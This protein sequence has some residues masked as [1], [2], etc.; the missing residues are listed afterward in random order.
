M[1]LYGNVIHRTSPIKR[2]IS[3]DNASA[4]KKSKVDSSDSESGGLIKKFH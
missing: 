3:L 1:Y 4:A 2:R